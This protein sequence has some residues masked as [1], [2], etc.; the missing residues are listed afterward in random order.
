MTACPKILRKR[1]M[2]R[3][4]EDGEIMEVAE[5]EP[6]IKEFS[7]GYD[8]ELMGD[9]D[10]RA[11]LL[12]LNEFEREQELY[13]R[14]LRRED[15]Q[16][17]FDIQW[18]LNKT[19][20]SGAPEENFEIKERSQM[21]RQ[22]LDHQRAGN[23]RASAFERLMALRSNKLTKDQGSEDGTVQAGGR[24][25]LQAQQVK[26]VKLRATD[27]YSDDS[28][29]SS[30]SEDNTPVQPAAKDQSQVT[31]LEQLG[32]AILTR[33]Q[34]ESFLDRPIF[35]ETVVGCFVRVNVSLQ[36]DRSNCVY[37]IVGLQD[38]KEEY[39]LGSKRTKLVLR[40][41]FGAQERYSLMDV[42][43]NQRV[44]N[45][46][47]AVWVAVCQRDMQPLPLLADIDKKQLDV[48]RASEYSFT[49]GD[50][51][52]LIQT[53]QKAGQ[54]RVSSAYRKVCLIME[55]DMAV[56]LNDME[57]VKDLERQI[58]EIDEQPTRSENTQERAQ[59]RA[60]ERLQIT[61]SPCAHVPTIHRHEPMTTSGSKRSFPDR[62]PN[63]EEFELE[64]YMRRKYKKSA[65]VSRCR[66][67]AES[68]DWEEVDPQAE[69]PSTDAAGEM[70][71][72]P[73]LDLHE[74]HDFKVVI[75]TKGMGV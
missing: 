50:V 16:R 25:V 27:I 24:N 62:A 10:D 75:D 11:R 73:E 21:R 12:H 33:S 18:Q 23:K 19:R 4:L 66:V 35:E 74:L 31:T 8:E 43:S 71:E 6:I 44:T 48:E 2:S 17:K 56:G 41:R 30:S 5:S 14:C 69:A 26:K 1:L 70:E 52:K 55:R 22:N 37:Q 42:V 68:E 38:R 63:S 28:S 47:F 9:A 51:E 59:E 54:K 65:V 20:M 15:L 49:E 46:E 67:E 36:P 58:Q 7:D 34:L 3:D 64:Q 40:L 13:Q 60:Q 32:R 72:V 61:S 39:Q 29:S 53:K 45:H 57:R